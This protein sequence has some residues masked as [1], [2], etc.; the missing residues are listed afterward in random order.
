MKSKSLITLLAVIVCFS[1]SGF[2]NLG[3][4]DHEDDEHEHIE[5]TMN[6]G[7]HDE[8]ESHEENED[9]EQA[10]E[11]TPEEIQEIGLATEVAGPG[12]VDIYIN[13]PGEIRINQDRMAHVVPR[14]EGIVTEVKKKLGDIVKADEVIAW[15][16]ST[17]LGKVKLEY[18]GKW[19]EMTCCALNLSRARQIHDNT[20]KLLDILDNSPSLETLQNAK[21]I[22]MGDNR[23]KLISAY[24]EYSFAKNA[25]EREKTLFE[26]N[27]SSEQA[28]LE[29]QNSFKKA[30]A[31]YAAIRDSIA[32][33]IQRNLLE[34]Q[35]AR[36]IQM[37]ELKGTE[38][39]LKI[40]GI[41][42]ENIRE[43]ELLVEIQKLSHTSED[44]C[45]D[46]NCTECMLEKETANETAPEFIEAEE[47][48]AWYPLVAPFDGTIVS[49]NIT[50]GEVAKEDSDAF[51][52]ADLNTVW[53][54][55]QVYPKDLRHIKKD[56]QVVISADSEIPEVNGI[57]SYVSPI[58]G[59]E[60]R[61]ALARV[62][63]SNESGMF[64]PGLFVDAKVSVSQ[65][66]A[67][68]VVPKGSI[69]ML[70][71]KKCVFVK[72]EHG[73]EPAFVEIG[74]ED[75]NHVE[76]L[77]GL[78]A[79]QEYVTKGAFSLKSKVATSTLDSHAGHGH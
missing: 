56:L 19:A 2:A 76:I 65:T 50:L 11:L 37:M 25:Y 24:A 28:F 69:Q 52:V 78:T 26:Q 58:V 22:E 70:E 53:V 41:T 32:F 57:I 9:R 18:V 44:D 47:K 29:T 73:F 6:P 10:I 64:R 23:S 54:D 77:S 51:V 79:G 74:L 8:P 12:T 1:L 17:T 63:L 60:S 75:T 36:Q 13:L 42:N 67:E 33:E 68:V 21:G 14:V 35:R 40:L 48:L 31:Q 4:S 72:D 16:E 43:L 49:K 45:D 34:A 7:N 38:R 30:D 61:T 5:N 66:K 55:L 27:I 62:V 3:N 20:I 46:P 59:T 15:I 71:G 39:Q